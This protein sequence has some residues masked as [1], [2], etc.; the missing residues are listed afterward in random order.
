MMLG[1]NG[2]P[3]DQEIS[4]YV[5]ADRLHKLPHEIREMPYRDL[6][7]MAAFYKVSGVLA[8]MHAEHAGK[9]T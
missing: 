4:V 2:R 5:L 3:V 9:R 1:L 8:K 6:V 7:H